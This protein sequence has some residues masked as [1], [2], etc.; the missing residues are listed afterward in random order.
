V[1][2]LCLLESSGY[3]CHNRIKLPHQQAHFFIPGIEFCQVTL[4][5][6]DTKN[7]LADQYKKGV[8][9]PAFCIAR[10]QNGKTYVET[11]S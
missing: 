8:P 2:I 4:V 1:L 10:N 7:Q 3:Q 5:R 9:T 6:I 11:E